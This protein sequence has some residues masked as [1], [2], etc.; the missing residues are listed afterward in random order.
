MLAQRQED[1]KHVRGTKNSLVWLQPK[2][3]KEKSGWKCPLGGC[4][5]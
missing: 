2:L 4:L 1:G 5:K 3:G